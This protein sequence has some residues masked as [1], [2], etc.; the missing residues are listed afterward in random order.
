MGMLALQLPYMQDH[1]P[2]GVAMEWK[3]W[4]RKKAGPGTGDPPKKKLPRPKELLQ[5][6]GQHLVTVEKLDPDLVWSLFCV[7]RPHADNKVVSDVRVFNPG[8]ASVHGVHVV[9]YSSLDNHPELILYHGWVDSHSN[10]F[11]LQKSAPDLAA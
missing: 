8:Q 10:R 7:L 1:Q 11:K 4:N 3:F 5:P 6:I 9:D 2:R